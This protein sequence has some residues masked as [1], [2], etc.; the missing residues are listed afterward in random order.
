MVL[1]TCDGLALTHSVFKLF[2][3]GPT[4]FTGSIAVICDIRVGALALAFWSS[5]G[6]TECDPGMYETMRLYI[7]KPLEACLGEELNDAIYVEEY[8]ICFNCWR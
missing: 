7:G 5:F 2:P 1:D 4:V 3:F 6:D 8:V